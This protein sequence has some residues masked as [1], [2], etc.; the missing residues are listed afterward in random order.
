MEL[1]PC[2]FCGHAPKFERLGTSRQS[3]IVAC[4]WCGCRHE[5]SDEGEQCGESWNTRYFT[6]THDAMRRQETILHESEAAYTVKTQP[7]DASSLSVVVP[8]KKPR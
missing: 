5:S 6:N 4:G 8:I 2:P 1:L 7:I 3:C